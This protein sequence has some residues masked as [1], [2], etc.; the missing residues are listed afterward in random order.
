MK[1][2]KNVIQGVSLIDPLPL[3]LSLF[4]AG[5]VIDSFLSFSFQSA[6]KMLWKQHLIAATA[7]IC[8]H[9]VKLAVARLLLQRLSLGI[10]FRISAAVVSAR[11]PH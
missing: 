2:G 4:L 1:E 3:S 7:A 5:A 11:L 8:S 9:P 6:F 10:E